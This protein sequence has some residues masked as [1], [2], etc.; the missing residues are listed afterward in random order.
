MLPEKSKHGHQCRRDCDGCGIVGGT[1]AATRS[2]E[3]FDPRLDCQ[4]TVRD[5]LAA[6]YRKSIPLAL[7]LRYTL[8]QKHLCL[9]RQGYRAD[10]GGRD[11]LCH[12]ANT[13][14]ER[15]SDYR[16]SVKL[17]EKVGSAEMM[18]AVWTYH[19]LVRGV[20]LWTHGQFHTVW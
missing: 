18:V 6:T 14:L 1:A 19:V 17:R 12:P 5:T 20:V 2:F 4:L 16:A 9:G 11:L 10:G 15:V 8:S 13:L 7:Q 3:L